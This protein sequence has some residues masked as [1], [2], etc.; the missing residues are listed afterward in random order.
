MSFK[1]NPE[2]LKVLMEAIEKKDISI[3]NRFIKELWEKHERINLEGANLEG[4]NFVGAILRN[5]NLKEANL[6][7]QI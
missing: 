2:H 6:K 3:W 1:G 7:R 4:V 5:V